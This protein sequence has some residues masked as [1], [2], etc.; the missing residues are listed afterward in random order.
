MRAVPFVS[1]FV[2]TFFISSV[3]SAQQPSQSGS[4]TPPTITTPAKVEKSEAIV[5]K[6]YG[7]IQ[8]SLNIE[9]TERGTEPDTV[10]ISPLFG[11]KV[12]KADKIT[13]AIEVRLRGNFE[14]KS[15]PNTVEMRRS[16]LTYTTDNATSFTLGRFRHITAGTA[17]YGWIVD[18]SNGPGFFGS[19][20]GAMIG[21]KITLAEKQ[22]INLD[23]AAVNSLGDSAAYKMDSPSP[24][25]AR[26][27]LGSTR[28]Q[29]GPLNGGLAYGYEPKKVLSEKDEKD[30]KLLNT[31]AEQQLVK[32]SFG[33]LE[34][35]WGTGIHFSLT[36]QGNTQ[37][38]TKDTRGDFSLGAKIADSKKD[39]TL[40][41]GFRGNSAMFDYTDLALKGDRLTFGGSLEKIQ[42]RTSGLSEEAKLAE[43]KKDEI[44][45]SFGPGYTVDVFQIELVYSANFSDTEKFKNNLGQENREKSK[46]NVYLTSYWLF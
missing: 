8:S 34:E 15:G 16:Q 43:K 27:Y 14:S 22:I 21:Q 20:D 7:Y 10:A 38:F 19:H 40:G 35:N 23:I 30:A 3:A 26:A 6:P 45:I 33:Y 12:N 36:S 9:D 17:F 24:Y 31:L 46:Q 29:F 39:L 41:I 2:S 13:G 5:I 1:T 42:T 37:E 44:Q 28:F 25:K 18:A 11:V 32:G 4:S